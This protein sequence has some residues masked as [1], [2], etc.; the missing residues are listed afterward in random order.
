MPPPAV[1]A[2]IASGCFSQM[3]LPCISRLVQ[4]WVT[5]AVYTALTFAGKQQ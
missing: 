2:M 4:R 5:T 3:R 1:S